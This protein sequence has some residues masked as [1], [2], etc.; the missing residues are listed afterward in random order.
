MAPRVSLP[1]CVEKRD[2]LTSVKRTLID[3]RSRSREVRS[4]RRMAL[5]SVRDD[6]REL[7]GQLEAR[8]RERPKGT[9]AQGAASVGGGRPR[10]HPR[11][12]SSTGPSWSCLAVEWADHFALRPPLGT[13]SRRARH[14]GARGHPDPCR[15]LGQGRACRSSGRVR[16]LHLCAAHS[17]AL[18]VLRAPVPDRYLSRGPGEQGSGDRRRRKHGTV[19]RRS[20][21]FRDTRR[22]QPDQ[23]DE[24]P[25]TD[26]KRVGDQQGAARASRSRRCGRPGLPWQGRRPTTVCRRYDPAA[27]HFAEARQRVTVRA[28]S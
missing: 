23:P 24:L 26:W 19:D 17:I 16:K 15:R 12:P 7:Q 1:R 5:S 2:R 22:R 21:A 18:D 9:A 13:A 4:V 25:L 14:R 11:W 8:E 6:R 27:A 3:R 10:S 28:T 20:P